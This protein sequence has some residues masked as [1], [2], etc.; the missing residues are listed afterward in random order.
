MSSVAQEPGAPGTTTPQ[1]ILATEALVSGYGGVP[2][3]RDLN[4]ELYPG[5]VVAFLG[6]NGAGKTTTILTLAGEVRPISGRVLWNGQPLAGPLHKRARAGLRLIPEE[7]SVFMSLSVQDNIRL[8]HR[9]VDGCV[10][11][12]P[13][14]KPLLG[15]KAGLLSGGE[16]QMLTLARA[17][18]SD[19]RVLL[20][21]EL[22][23]GLAPLAA[24]RLLTAV[25]AAAGR[26][27]AVILVEQSLE[28][29][30]RVADRG[31]VFQRG[32]VVMS[33]DAAFIKSHRDQ[34][35]SS[36]LSGSA[37]EPADASPD[38]D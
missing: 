4:I 38:N 9:S 20:A 21:D 26:G 7:R 3:V 19:C 34:V 25:R 37:S 13:E 12:F 31:Y 30:M 11:L 28:R 35:E 23:L 2:I 24:E 33:G 10:D 22:S 18:A 27:T 29:A 15:R 8:A 16:Q 6:A 5:E 14:L 17:L 32:R 1:P 36:Y